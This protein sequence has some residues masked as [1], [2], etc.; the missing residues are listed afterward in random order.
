MQPQSGVITSVKAFRFVGNTLL[1]NE[2]LAP[3]VAAYLNHPL[4]FSQLQAAAAAIA[5][6]YREAGWIVRAY[7]PAQDIADGVVTIQIVEAVFGGAH[8]QGDKAQRVSNEQLMRIVA[9]QL[10]TGEPLNAD[11][12]D[13]ALLLADD[14]PGATVAGGLREGAQDHETDVDLKLG[15]EPLAVGEVGADNTGARSTGSN[16]LTANLSLNSP[17]KHG[18]LISANVMHTQG[19]DYLRLDG[20]I[21]LGS[22]GW[23]SGI[24][25]SLLNYKLV[26]PEFTALDANGTSNTV[27]VEATYPL[28]RSRLKNLYLNLNADNKNFDNLSSGATT[29]N[30]KADTV[31]I[32]LDG[33]FFDNL[34]GGGANSTSLSLVDGRLN[35]DGSPNQAADA[36]TTQAA[37]HYDKVRYAANRQQVI[38]ETV[39]LFASYSGQIASKN[40]D[41]SEKFYLGGSGGVRAYPAS[42]GGGSEGQLADL[43]LRWRLPHGFNFTGFYDYGHVLINKD[44]SFTGAS[45]LNDYALKGAGLSLAWQ[46]DKGSTL[47]ATYARRLGDNPNP[48]LAGNDQDGSLVKDRLWLTASFPFSGGGSMASRLAQPD[49]T[50]GRATA[51]APSTLAV[52]HVVI[53]PA[54]AADEASGGM[55]KIAENETAISTNEATAIEAH[56]TPTACD[57]KSHIKNI[58]DESIYFKTGS[59][60]V[61]SSCM[62]VLIQQAEYIKAHPNELFVLQG[63]ADERG[64]PKYNL[65]LSYR[66]ARA[67]RTNMVVLGIPASRVRV[68]GSGNKQRRL[69]CSEEKCWHENRRVDLVLRP[70]SKEQP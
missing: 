20:N 52:A 61:L 40:L 30:Y 25:A 47:K 1:S 7:L 18:D 10:K 51:P 26:A 8:I 46:S 28:I 69:T 29:T 5:N 42:E 66:R 59:I 14:L 36:A 39:S 15:D 23:R 70:I 57:A 53:K 44:N 27:G 43:E 3:V 62:D 49:E 19:S 54:K 13:R 63:N 45:A 9:A 56:Q 64:K 24:N 35:L 4:D 2:K 58:L 65:D 55:S 21:P 32:G 17:F 34:G 68:M 48:A 11:K 22:D 6:A 33:N 41:S 38:T 50:S 12:L 16:R 60:A 67:V 37:G 31:T